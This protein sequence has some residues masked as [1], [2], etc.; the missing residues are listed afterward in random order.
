MVKRQS[1]GKAVAINE[2]YFQTCYAKKEVGEVKIEKEAHATP[3]EN[4]KIIARS[5]IKKSIHSL[6]YKTSL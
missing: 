1:Q 2:K 3:H 6:G 5:R 4:P